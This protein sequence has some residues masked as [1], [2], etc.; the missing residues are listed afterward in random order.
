MIKEKKDRKAERLEKT[1]MQLQAHKGYYY[2]K[3]RKNYLAAREKM[4]AAAV[5]KRELRKKKSEK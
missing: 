4:L 2:R 5:V 3:W 1:I